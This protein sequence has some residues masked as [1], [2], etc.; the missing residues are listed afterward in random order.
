MAPHA[1]P[2]LIATGVGLGLVGTTITET[3]RISDVLLYEEG[4]AMNFVRDT[5]TL[6]S[7]GAACV[8]GQVLARIVTAGTATETHAGNTGNGA[9]TLDVTTPVLANAMAGVYKVLCTAAASNS[10]TFRV[11]DPLGRVLGDVA[12]AGTFADQIKFVIADG[13]TD[14]I[15]GDT[16]LVKVVIDTIKY[17]QVNPAGADGSQIASA[18]ALAAADPTSADVTC[19]AVVRGPAVL[20]DSGLVWTSGMSTG[21]KAAARTQL[22]AAGMKVEGAYGA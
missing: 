13:A 8:I 1:W 9:M 19:L 12:V 16:F 6:K 14:F 17:V 3:A 18:V 20:K 10:G 5:V 22:A 11:F 21:Q 2:A 15:V 4:E 7:G